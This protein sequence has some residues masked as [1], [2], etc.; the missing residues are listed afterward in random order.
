MGCCGSTD[1]AR[2]AGSRAAGR[3]DWEVGSW[4]R[5]QACSGRSMSKVRAAQC[6]SGAGEVL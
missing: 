5:G 3:C 6:V 1:E 4:Q 2:L